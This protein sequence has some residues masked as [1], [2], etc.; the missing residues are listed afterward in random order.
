MKFCY[1]MLKFMCSVL[2]VQ[3]RLLGPFFPETINS[4]LYVTNI[5][6]IQFCEHLSD[7]KIQCNSS[8]CKHLPEYKTILT[9]VL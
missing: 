9:V 1:M 2:L 6:T 7:C 4:H 5:V 3:L 8:C